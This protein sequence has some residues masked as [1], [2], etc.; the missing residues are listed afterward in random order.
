[1]SVSLLF[2]SVSLLFHMSVSFFLL[3]ISLSRRVEARSLVSRGTS[4]QACRNN[5]LSPTPCSRPT[6]LNPPSRALFI[7]DMCGRIPLSSRKFQVGTTSLLEFPTRS[8]CSVVGTRCPFAKL[9]SR[10]FAQ[11]SDELR[12]PLVRLSEG[13]GG[14][15]AS[16]HMLQTCL[17]RLSCAAHPQLPV[18]FR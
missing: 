1:M 11:P 16:S 9:P 17:F 5:S 15:S 13:S 4:T 2:M 3:T 6:R 18:G 8:P 14:S 10:R 12:A 7:S